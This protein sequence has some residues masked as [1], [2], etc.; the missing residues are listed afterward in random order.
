VKSFRGRHGL[1]GKF[2]PGLSCVIL[3]IMSALPKISYLSPED[4]LHAERLAET[5]SDYLNGIMVAM[6]GATFRH[7]VIAGNVFR[8]IGNAFQNRPCIVF[9]SDMK[10][11]VDKANSFRYPDVSAL[12]GPINFYDRV[13]DIY[14]NPRFICEV[15]SPS[16][17][18]TD[19]NEKFAGYRLIDT[20]T[21]YLIIE[22]D[23]MEVDLHRKGD[24]GIWTAQTYIEITEQIELESI[25]VNLTLAEIYEK[26]EFA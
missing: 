26:I 23:K 20:F 11:R 10:V 9:G 3:R 24:N 5:K 4:Y 15:L 16:T 14:C 12:C 22:Q 6:S 13:T 8:R 2:T 21:E 17:S 18:R 25:G 1:S 19:R 7:N